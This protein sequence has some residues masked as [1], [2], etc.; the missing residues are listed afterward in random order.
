MYQTEVKDRMAIASAGDVIQRGDSGYINDMFTVVS[1]DV[2]VGGF[3]Q[4]K[5]GGKPNEIVGASGVAITGQVVGVVEKNVY[6]AGNTPS[7]SIPKGQT[8]SVLVKGKIAIETENNCNVGDYV[9]LQK[10][11]GALVFS[12][13]KMLKDDHVFTGFSVVEGNDTGE[14]GIIII[15]SAYDTIAEKSYIE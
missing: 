13:D 4:R 8:I 2:V 10:S 12:A 5:A 9:F 6:F 3:V 7:V 14:E 1:D 15:S 11:N